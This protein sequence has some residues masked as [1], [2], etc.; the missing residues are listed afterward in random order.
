MNRIIIVPATNGFVVETSHQEGETSLTVATNPKELVVL[1]GA[2]VVEKPK[3]AK[4]P[5]VVE[6]TDVDAGDEDTERL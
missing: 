5:V 6:E 4:R 3:P 2:L 1:I